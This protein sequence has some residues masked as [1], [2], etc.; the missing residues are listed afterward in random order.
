MKVQRIALAL[1][2]IAWGLNLSR[3]AAAGAEEMAGPAFSGQGEVSA[4]GDTPFWANWTAG[5]NIS[6]SQADRATWPAL[7]LSAD[8]QIVYAAWSDGRD[9]PQNIYYTMAIHGGD[10]WSGVQ[11]VWNSAAPSLRPSMVLLGTTPLLT[12]A[13][14]TSPL[15]HVT[16]QM[17]LGGGA[18]VV[19][20]NSQTVLAYVSRLALGP[21]NEV[22]LVL[23]GDEAG[24]GG[25]SAPDILFTRRA[26]AATTWPAASVVFDHLTS[27]SYYPAMA[28]GADR[29]VHLAWQETD[30][31]DSAIRYMRGQRS[32]QDILWNASIDVSG[33]VTRS[34]R[35]AVA[36]GPGSDVYIAWGEKLLNQTQYVR[37][38]RSQNGGL[39]WSPPQR[40]DAEPVSANSVAPTDVAPALV[41][42]PSGAIC[43]A[44]HGF[45]TGSSIEAE[46]IYVTCS[47]NRGV[48]WAT[49]VNI[50]RTSTVIS[51]RP[52]MA[53]GNDGILHVVWQEY[54]PKIG[55]DARYNYQ[56]YYAHSIPY[57]AYLP[58]ITRSSR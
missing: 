47:T 27:G 55:N 44:W 9:A 25:L 49:P 6:Q 46:E 50:S 29:T 42:T 58:S 35:P 48:T 11:R 18:P 19:V 14:E 28:V 10:Q 41:V 16:Y 34:V 54:V 4:A 7:A 22:H 43:A 51:I 53:V 12:W 20:P 8:G 1:I 15:N 30:G 36:L 40:I 31:T 24:G 2:L 33:V 45:R 26:A 3:S 38:A 56:I 57:V 17:A 21:D 32:G 39:T 23:Q 13:D 5:R 52:V 37:F